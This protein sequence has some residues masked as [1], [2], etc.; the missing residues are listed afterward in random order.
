MATVVNREQLKAY[1]FRALGAPL[2]NIDVAAEQIEDRIDEAIT[3]FSRIDVREFN[4]VNSLTVQYDYITAYLDFFQGFPEF[5]KAKEMYQK[6]K[7][8]PLNL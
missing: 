4:N 3:V 1:V 7:D 8:F 2:I 5:N 6:N